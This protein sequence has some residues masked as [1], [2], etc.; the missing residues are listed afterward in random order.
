M[1]KND[2][3]AMCGKYL[4]DPAIVLEDEFVQKV[5]KED[6]GK[7]TVFNEITLNTYIQ[8]NF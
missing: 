4:V 5:L 8:L 3:N 6:K 7:H 1:T 2:F